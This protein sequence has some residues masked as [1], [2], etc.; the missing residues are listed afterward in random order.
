[1]FSYGA[2][3]AYR[4][5]RCEANVGQLKSLAEGGKDFFKLNHSH[6]N[7][8]LCTHEESS[9][10]MEV[11]KAHYSPLEWAVLPFTLIQHANLKHIP[12]FK[13]TGAH[14]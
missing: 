7:L 9:R 10:I 6:S 11:N 8:N 4:E 12:L 5:E 14:L 3:S 13:F 1:M 2:Q